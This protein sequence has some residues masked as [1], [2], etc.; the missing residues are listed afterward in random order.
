M[1]ERWTNQTFQAGISLTLQ[2][3]KKPNGHDDIL[4]AYGGNLVF[5]QIDQNMLSKPTCAIE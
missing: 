5:H 2:Q 4:K 1:T 3:L